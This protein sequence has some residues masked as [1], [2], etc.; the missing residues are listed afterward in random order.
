MATHSSVHLNIPHRDPT[1]LQLLCK[2]T[3]WVI[4]GMVVPEFIVVMAW[5]QM[6]PA[7]ALAAKINS[8]YKDRVASDIECPKL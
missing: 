3:K 2:K 4:L 8:I 1:T 5:T 7:R 6:Q